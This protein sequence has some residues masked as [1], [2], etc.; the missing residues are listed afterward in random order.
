[1]KNLELLSLT[2][3]A[4]VGLL[5]AGSCEKGDFGAHPYDPNTPV[6]VSQIPSISSFSPTEGEAG[7]TIV[8]SGN[9]FISPKG[10]EITSV[11][12]G[13]KAATFFEILDA[14]TLR[15]V[16]SSYGANGAVVVAN[17]KGSASLDGFRFIKPVVDD[18]PN[19]ALSAIVDCEDGITGNKANINDG[20]D[21][22]WWQCKE[23]SAEYT[24]TLDLTRVYTINEVI[25]KWDPYAAGTDYSISYSEDGETY[26]LIFAET[27]WDAVA[28]SGKKIIDFDRLNARYVRLV[29]KNTATPWN[30][31][32]F[33]FQVYN[34]PDPV[35]L[36]LDGL[37]TAS[38]AVTGSANNL[39]DGK[40]GSWWQ[41]KGNENE[42]VKIDLY[43]D[44]E[45]N[46]VILTWDMNAAGTDYTLGYSSDD[47][48]YT[49]IKTEAGWD[50]VADN[51]KKTINFD[52]VKGRYVKL[53][54]M[55]NT[56]TPWNMTLF[57]FEIYKKANR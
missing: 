20:L 14:N 35:N 4:G 11:T 56:A 55:S 48:E 3:L 40:F 24:I 2:A 50:A 19:L 25:L 5:F 42:W 53:Y 10:Y 17:E 52:T 13:G 6:T 33:E 47:K 26:T 27:G 38:D 21:N 31:T 7:D 49:V 43:E 15:A 16:V 32:L 1:M 44:K 36:S 37:A 23:A 12:F 8:V 39:I 18:N 57:E 34:V 46:Q 22:T 30:M 28:D 41:A 45:F 51:G 54:D 9:N 29:C